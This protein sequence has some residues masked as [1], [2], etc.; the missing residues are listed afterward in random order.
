MD[1]PGIALPAHRALR[2]LRRLRERTGHVEELALAR[3]ALEG[4]GRHAISLPPPDPLGVG[5][6]YKIGRVKRAGRRL[7]FA[8]CLALLAGC[9]GSGAGTA[10][11]K[12]DWVARHGA[13]ITALNTQLDFARAALAKGDRTEI[14]SACNL[15]HD[16]LTDA[17][18]VLPAPN[19]AVDAALRQGFD[20]VTTG[21]A[22]CL[23]GARLADVASITERAMAELQD[24]RTR[25]DSA[26]RAIAAWV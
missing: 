8:V 26:N 17:R 1:P 16:D 23:Q 6:I 14:L 15:L 20:A 9:G 12:A 18:A 10:T 25:M 4:V 7:A 2:R 22:D 13:A 5:D 24:A 21:A 19:P 11:S 3:Q